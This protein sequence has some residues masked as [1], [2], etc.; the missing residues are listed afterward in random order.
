MGRLARHL[1]GGGIYKK[2][3]QDKKTTLRLAKEK[4]RLGAAREDNSHSILNR[5]RQLR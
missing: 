5:Q 4:T 2:E 1:H 3:K